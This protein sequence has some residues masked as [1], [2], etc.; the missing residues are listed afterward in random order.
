MRIQFCQ[1]LP[2]HFLR[3]VF[4]QFNR[5]LMCR[6]HWNVWQVLS[7]SYLVLLFLVDNANLTWPYTVECNAACLWCYGATTQLHIFLFCYVLVLT[8]NNLSK[9]KQKMFEISHLLVSSIQGIFD[10]PPFNSIPTMMAHLTPCLHSLQFSFR[11]FFFF[12]WQS[13]CRPYK[14]QYTQ[15]LNINGSFDGFDR[16]VCAAHAFTVYT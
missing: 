4:D 3:I 16:I 5:S 6:I 1:T 7:I 13:C 8:T 10:F 11:E 9:C 2:S 15:N 12:F 14:Q